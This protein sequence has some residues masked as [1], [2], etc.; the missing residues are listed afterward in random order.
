MALVALPRATQTGAMADATKR[1][2]QIAALIA[3]LY[4]TRRYCR[5][6]GATK[7]ECQVRLPGDELVGDPV[8]QVTEAVWVDA[9]PSA[10][11]PWLLQMGQDRGGIYSCQALENLFGLRF[12]N[13][14]RVHPEWQH[15]A[16]GDVVRLA[17]NRWMRLRDGLTLSVDAITPERSIVLRA[18]TPNLP[19]AV[20]S[21]HLQR[22]GNGRSR[23]LARAR[24]GLRHPGEVFAMELVRPVVA[25]ATR[26]VLLGIKRRVQRQM[27][28]LATQDFCL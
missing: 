23:L 9:P 21:F 13:A 4:A 1:F 14:D 27:N 11:W 18:T 24:V 6:W 8:I 10:V 3:V 28:D 2:S 25:L 15:L 22:H 19:K 17:P 7:E 26:G 20:W 16:V 12:R 5:N